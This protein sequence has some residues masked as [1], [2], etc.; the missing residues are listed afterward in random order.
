MPSQNNIL[1]ARE[2]L[3][4][5]ESPADLL[6]GSDGAKG[7][8]ETRIRA[9]PPALRPTEYTAALLKQLRLNSDAVLGARVLE[10]GCGSGVILAALA[11]FGAQSVCGIDIEDEAV[12]WASSLLRDIGCAEA[13]VYR[14]DLWEPV[15]GRKFDLIAANLPHFPMQPKSFGSRPPSWGCGGADGRRFLDPFLQGL[16]AHL[17]RG[18]RAIITHNAFVELDRSREILKSGGLVL[19]VLDTLSVYIPQEKLELISPVVLMRERD[20]TLW[21]FG[22][23]A[24]ADMHI[25]QITTDP[26]R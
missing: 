20:R 21:K 5:A 3:L 23:Y 7:F 11:S 4:A 9:C 25:V 2:T 22:P 19:D 10:M 16:P 17:E 24:F 18:G 12:F 26:G 8:G 14:G 13:I 15:A 1:A 6:S